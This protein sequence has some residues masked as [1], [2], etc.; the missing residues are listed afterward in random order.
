MLILDAAQIVSRVSMPRMIE[1]VRAGFASDS[2]APKRQMLSLPGGDGRR[3][4]L[5]MPAFELD[6]SGIVKLSTIVPDNP[7]RTLPHI[8]GVLVVFSEHGE[9]L[10]ILD[11]AAVTRLRTAAASACASSYLSR[12]DSAHLLIVGSGALAPYMAQAH[13]AMRPIRRV[14]VWGRH[15]GRV[16]TAVDAIRGLLGSDVKVVSASELEPAV[17]SA[18]IVCCAT[19]SSSP[20]LSGVWLRPGTFV[21]LVGNFSPTGSEIDD[22]VL[23][24]SR[25]YVDTLEGAL[26]EAG[27]LL[28]PLSR[29]VITRQAIVGELSDLVCARIQGRRSA[30][31]ITLFKSVGAALEDLVA[32]KLIIATITEH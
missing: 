3:Q 12:E 5:M 11:G 18:D 10:A 28:G 26:A 2:F 25:V 16:A 32:A 8:Q 23:R 19:S 1:A 17:A 7:A 6:G 4:L 20:V 30:D 24:R 31:E 9:P 27:D 13:C 21:D 15:A 29:G 22:E 14:S